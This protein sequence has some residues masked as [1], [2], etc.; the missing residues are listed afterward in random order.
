[1]CCWLL[2]SAV[3]WQYMNAQYSNVTGNMTTSFLLITFFSTP[4]RSSQLCDPCG[5]TTWIQC[6]HMS[7][8]QIIFPHTSVFSGWCFDGKTKGLSTAW[9]PFSGEF[10][11]QCFL[12]SQQMVKSEE[13][14]NRRAWCWQGCP[15]KEAARQ[16]GSGL[17]YF[18]RP[19]PVSDSYKWSVVST[20]FFFYQ[21]ISPPI[22]PPQLSIAGWLCLH[23][24]GELLLAQSLLEYFKWKLWC[25]DSKGWFIITLVFIDHPTAD[26]WPNTTWKSFVQK[27]KIW[28]L[29]VTRGSHLEYDRVNVLAE[30]VEEEPVAHVALPD[31]RVYAFFFHTPA[32]SQF[33]SLVAKK[34]HL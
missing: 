18:H 33:T 12:N 13:K 7:S 28:L 24:N 26:T 16:V 11:F 30:Q 3:M 34:C 1:M 22:I 20:P 14:E 9:K 27:R 21:T 19:A 5:N 25:P 29:S 10:K 8:D 17:K 32:T 4:S 31:D 23:C 6:E 2:F 15:A